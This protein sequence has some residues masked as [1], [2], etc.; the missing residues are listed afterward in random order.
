MG[1]WADKRGSQ[2]FSR[3]R[4]RF[5]WGGYERLKAFELALRGDTGNLKTMPRRR[6]ESTK[7]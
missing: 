1:A 3:A 2:E 4:C 6:I 5:Q 7:E